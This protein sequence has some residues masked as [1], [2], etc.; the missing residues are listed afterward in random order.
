MHFKMLFIIST[1]IVIV[2]SIILLSLYKEEIIYKYKRYK[3]GKVGENL[4]SD[5][6]ALLDDNYKV[7]NNLLFCLKND[8]TVQMDHIVVSRTGVYVIETKNYRGRIQEVDDC[9]WM[10]VINGRDYLFY[11]PIKQ[12]ESHIKSLMYILFTKKRDIFK[13]IVAFPD[14]TRLDLKNTKNIIKFRN[15]C[16]AIEKSQLHLLTDEEVNKIC[17]KIEEKN[18]YNK[19]NLKK[20]RDRIKRIYG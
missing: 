1:I 16:N 18:I 4:I 13:S 20:H 3:K 12:N 9:N 5:K 11:N 7:Y 15:I 19:K 2:V 8:I 14:N 6:L 17:Q 10:Q